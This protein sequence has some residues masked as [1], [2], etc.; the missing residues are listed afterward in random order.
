MSYDKYLHS[1]SSVVLLT[2]DGWDDSW[3]QHK[4]FSQIET[5]ALKELIA[6]YPYVGFNICEEEEAAKQKNDLSEAGYYALGKGADMHSPLTFIDRSIKDGSFF[7]NKVLLEALDHVKNNNSRLHLLGVASDAKEYS[8]L[9]HVKNLLILARDKEVKEVYIHVILD[10]RD[11][12]PDKGVKFVNQIQNYIKQLN[13]GKIATIHGSFYAMDR[14]NNWERVAKSYKALTES[15]GRYSED[16]E[17][18]IRE[19]YS[20]EIYDKEFLPTVITEQGNPRGLVGEGDSVIFFNI[21][22]DRSRELT[23]AFVMSSWD[24][25]PDRKYVRNLYFVCFTEYEKHLPIKIAF[26]KIRGSFC[27]SEILSN[28]EYPQ[29]KI[30]GVEKF[31]HLNYFFNGEKLTQF[32]FEDRQLI[33]REK[34]KDMLEGR[35]DVTHRIGEEMV[36]TIKEDKYKFIL[37]NIGNFDSSS[38]VGGTKKEKEKLAEQ[39]ETIDGHIKKIARNIL[40]KDGAL[41][42]TSTSNFFG[43]KK[44]VSPVPAVV[45]KKELEGKTLNWPQPSPENLSSAPPPGSLK[46]FKDLILT[47]I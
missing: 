31:P 30:S 22:G 19:S 23:K 32:P 44:K 36:K 13:I 8:S 1:A 46:D 17:E 35:K 27:L 43:N 45:V 15:E 4:L 11:T 18:I 29:L 26:S 39:V 10:G 2:I 47:M 42:I 16:P 28:K 3:N 38:F 5:P 9:Q 24:K 6:S 14:N 40:N 41:I 25:I 37:A 21:K 33:S 20:K 7:E 34:G 12:A